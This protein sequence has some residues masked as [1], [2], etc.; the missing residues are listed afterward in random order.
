M[1]NLTI[2]RAKRF[3]G[4]FGKMKVYIEDP[5]SNEITINGVP[6]RKI[7]ELKNGEEKTFEIDNGEAKVFVIADKLSR[8]YCNDFFQ[9]HEGQYDVY[10][11]GKNKYNPMIG[12]PFRFDNNDSEEALKKNKKNSR[13]GI[14]LF[15]ACIL[16]GAVIGFVTASYP[17]S[18]IK[19]EPKNFSKDGMNITL[20]NEF[21]VESDDY[22]TLTY[23]SE[24]AVIY[25]TKE[26]LSSN[27]DLEGLSTEEYAD[28]SIQYYELTDAKLKTENEL[29]SYSYT[30][31]DSETDEEYYCCTYVYKTN[32]AFWDVEFIT[33][34]EN[35]EEY[36]VKFDEWAASVTF[37][38]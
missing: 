15:F 11:S 7:G 12:N 37:S 35:R 1:R 31:E 29:T 8:N 17:F 28:M 27:E 13:I 24:Y 33:Y 22:Y 6:C 3:V 32:D 23:N 10:L 38:N 16:I 2:K 20:T 36:S 5:A 26:E 4:C 14:L 25:V 19:V 21:W 9:L 34:K 18:N 30:L